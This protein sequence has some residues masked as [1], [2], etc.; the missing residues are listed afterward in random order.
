[1]HCQGGNIR[2]RRSGNIRYA[3]K[4][5]G[6]WLK[7]TI[8]D[9]FRFLEYPEKVIAGW[10]Q[11]LVLSRGRAESLY[12]CHDLG[13]IDGVTGLLNLR[14]SF[15]F[16]NISLEQVMDSKRLVFWRW[17]KLAS[18]FHTKIINPDYVRFE[19]KSYIM[20]FWNMINVSMQFHVGIAILCKL[21]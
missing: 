1:M 12:L 5:V 17:S 21:L 10:N 20:K 6:A 7:I 18:Y 8:D 15:S 11:S 14:Q 16:G 9:K 4:Y 3:L 13:Q 2:H 19:N